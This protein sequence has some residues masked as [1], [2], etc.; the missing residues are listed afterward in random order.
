MDANV[1]HPYIGVTW[2]RGL[3]DLISCKRR[4]KRSGRFDNISRQLR[5]DREA[6]P[7][8]DDETRNFRLETVF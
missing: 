5:V 3:W 4:R 1:D 6:T 8:L 7:I 2:V